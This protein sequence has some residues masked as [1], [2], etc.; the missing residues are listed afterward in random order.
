MN[1]TAQKVGEIL[2][3]LPTGYYLGTRCKVSMD[4][5]LDTSKANPLTRE[6][7]IATCNVMDQLAGLPGD[8]D[9]DKAE[10]AVRAVLYHELSHVILTP[11]FHG[12]FYSVPR[13]LNVIEDER[14]ESVLRTYYKKVGFREAVMRMNHWN[15]ATAGE[16]RDGDDYAYRVIRYRHGP[17]DLLA[18]VDAFIKKWRNLDAASPK[19]TARR[20]YR[21]A[22]DLYGEICN[23]FDQEQEEK[24]RQQEEQQQEE[25][26]ESHGD[27]G[28]GNGEGTQSEDAESEEN[29]SEE[30]GGD[31]ENEEAGDGES[32]SGEDDAA[33][34]DSDDEGEGDESGDEDDAS[35]EGDETEDGDESE[36]TDGESEEAGDDDGDEGEAENENGEDESGEG[37]DGDD[38]NEEDGEAEVENEDGEA[39]DDADEIEKAA[40]EADANT[41]P[42]SM[43]RGKLLNKIQKSLEAVFGQYAN[44]AISEPLTR[45]VI[46][47]C[48]KRGTRG[49]ASNGYAGRI[50]PMSVG[51]R[52]DY[53]W[54][55]RRGDTGN[56]FD[57]VHLVLWTDV[58]GSFC[59]DIPHINELV[60]ALTEVERQMPRDFCFDV[61][62][63][64]DWVSKHDK[65]EP[66]ED[67]GANTFSVQSGVLEAAKAVAKPG[68]TTYNVAVWDGFMDDGAYDAGRN[69]MVN[70]Y[71]AK[72]KAGET[73]SDEEAQAAFNEGVAKYVTEQQRAAYN[74]LNT[75]K[76]IIVSDESNKPLLDAG[77]PN[78][79]RKYIKGDY[80]SQFIKAVLEMLDRIM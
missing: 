31:E 50:D 65:T 78:A 63:M 34:E 71:D 70:L 46:R 19:A 6:I 8:L 80:A 66:L 79:R 40:E 72:R 56:K 42:I 12:C 39:G 47:A 25:Q 55:Q 30:C 59:D 33:D 75:A 11:D 2:A 43:P 77:C 64:H 69:T 48:R 4:E 3:T 15:P 7:R 29:Q 41:A 37:E 62:E 60:A 16:A 23:R 9:A 38:G 54:W 57:R 24:R 53:R 28:D 76:T 1:I 27:E 68:W 26:Q 18:K 73:L 44:P 5:T 32:E 52:D 17:A 22:Q 36:D 20:Y 21:E 58:S 10:R 74:V 14:I 13:F 49:G 61:I 45:T 35:E 67:K 51:T